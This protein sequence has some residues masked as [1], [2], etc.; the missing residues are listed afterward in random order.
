MGSDRELCAGRSAQSPLCCWPLEA[1]AP[2]TSRNMGT[3]L[4]RSVWAWSDGSRGVSRRSCQWVSSGSSCRNGSLLARRDPYPRRT[5]P[6][7]Y[8]GS[9][10]GGLCPVLPGTQGARV[11]LLLPGERRSFPAVLFRGGDERGVDSAPLAA[12]CLDWLDGR[13]HD[14]HQAALYTRYTTHN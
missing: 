5:F 7:R 14:R 4:D 10:L 13:F 9:G 3:A 6:L 11:G 8:A 2:R 1:V 12:R